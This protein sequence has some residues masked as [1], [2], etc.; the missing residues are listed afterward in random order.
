[1][2]NRFKHQDS[3]PKEETEVTQ[4]NAVI[5]VIGDR[6]SG[7]TTYMA[8][9]ARGFNGNPNA[10]VQ[11]VMAINDDGR[12]LIAK[13]QNILEQGLELEP[14]DLNPQAENV[15]DYQLSITLKSQFSV[16]SI[17]SKLTKL[18]ISC[19]D[20]AGEFFSN[21]LH[22]PNDPT[23]ASYLEDCSQATGIMF[24]LDGSAS[25]KDAEYAI[26]IEKF[27]KSLSYSGHSSV[28]QRI[29]LVLTKCELPDL[30]MKRQ[31]PAN[32]ARTQFKQVCAKL[33]AW[34]AMT[35]SGN[36]EF[37]ATSAFGVIGTRFPEANSK[38]QSR[39]RGGVTSV[40]KDPQYWRPVGLVAPIYWLCEGNLYNQLNEE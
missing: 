32:L 14:T 29:A 37:F 38:E 26:S 12:E 9:L 25:R 1:M 28:L 24:L 21:S 8:A 35:G 18:N 33:R 11:D 6:A 36:L 31:Q 39:D 4:S 20:Y 19:K 16:K 23:L 10:L 40:I 30:W 22:Q 27:L 7:K 13:A 15:S 3:L 2:F 34:E 17:R 5:R